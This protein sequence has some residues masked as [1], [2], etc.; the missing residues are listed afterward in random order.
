MEHSRQEDAL[1]FYQG[2]VLRLDLTAGTSAVEPLNME[3]A[4]KYIGG[5]GLLLRYMWEDIPPGLDPWSPD[6]PVYLV[7]GPFA[8]TNVSTSSRLIV[9]CKSPVT[10]VLN[11]SYVG[12]SFAP[13]MKFAGYDI[14]IIT[15]RAPQPTVVTIRDDVVEFR[16]A[17]PKYWGMKTSE[18]EQAMRDDF[19]PNA[20]T[21][22]IGPAGEKKLAWACVSTDQYHKAGRGGHGAL[23]GDK[24]L[25]AV[26]VRGTGSVHVGDAKAFLADIWRIHNEHVLTDD[27]YWVHE[28]GTP[29]LVDLIN[30]A[31]AF[32]T[33][34]WSEGEFEGAGNIN[35]ESFQ[36]IRLK[37]RACYQC[38]IACRN[39]HGVEIGG[40]KVMGEGPEYETIALCGSN[41]C[42]GDIAA[43]V[44]FNELCDEW[45]MDTI[46][47]GSVLG[48]AMDL[49]E[50]GI[51]DFGVRF[52]DIDGYLKAPEL[53]ATRTG[54]GEEL[55]LGAK[56]LAEKY[57]V[58]ELAME[59]KN[60]ELPGYDPRGTFGMS[61][62]YAT[63]DRGG[64]HQRSYVQADEILG[65]DLPPDSLAGKAAVN[66]HWQNFTSV[67]Y[68][69]IWCEFWALELDEMRQLLRHVYGRDLPDE[70][71]MRVGERAWN[72]ARL[73]NLRESV[74]AD[75]LP[76]RLY[77]EEGAHSAGPSAGRSIGEAPFR[78]ALQEY[79]GLR[80]WDQ[81]G[82]PTEEKLREL[83]IDYRLEA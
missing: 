61:L 74:E 65:G 59:V 10:G 3:W 23:M 66:I 73:F 34:N 31:G 35:S 71:L 18:I 80:G 64:C 32:P 8:G 21:I 49:T 4:Q 33:R 20:R 50:K 51:K 67:K 58:P 76:R 39:V 41:C 69:G 42:I 56:H 26:S 15:G 17:Q 40:E 14:I 63:A 2:K 46:S 36:K 81:H 82:V 78:A 25:K 13:E 83:G 1:D 62:A 75:D 29:I 27:N 70:E 5:K 22:S 68:S 79:Y 43:L 37:K 7:T 38:A 9:G 6:N 72:L 48:L 12:G 45:G 54:I 30:G 16:P 19:D 52:G 55:A 57:G 77:S 24:N 47:S 11:D 44:K 28:E 60:L 53:M